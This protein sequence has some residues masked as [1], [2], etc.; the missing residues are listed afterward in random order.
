MNTQSVKRLFT[1]VEHLQE[2]DV[3][4]FE[5]RHI[6]VVSIDRERSRVR[7]VDA[8]PYLRSIWGTPACLN[9]GKG[10]SEHAGLKCLYTPTGLRLPP[11]DLRSWQ[12]DT[13]ANRDFIQQKNRQFD[14]RRKR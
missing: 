5:G 6:H 3:L 1:N 10:V 7:Y 2:G 13:L 12:D 9:C 11:Q 14:R 4:K 8:E